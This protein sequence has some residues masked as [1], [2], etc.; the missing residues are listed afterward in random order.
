MGSQAAN[1]KAKA[2]KRGTLDQSIR[3]DYHAIPSEERCVRLGQMRG[4]SHSHRCMDCWVDSG[5]TD[6]QQADIRTK[7]NED[8]LTMELFVEDGISMLA[9]LVHKRAVRTNPNG[10]H[11][12]PLTCDNGRREVVD[13]DNGTFMLRGGLQGRGKV[14]FRVG[15]FACVWGAHIGYCGYQNRAIKGKEWIRLFTAAMESLA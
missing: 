7:P 8:W 11:P 5:G 13:F 10:F 1:P 2:V 3:D 9:E 4:C 14:N 6:M 15:D 12:R